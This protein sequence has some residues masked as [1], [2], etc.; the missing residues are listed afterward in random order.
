MKITMEGKYQ[1]RGESG[2]LEGKHPSVRILCVDGP[3]DEP[4]IGIIDGWDKPLQWTA[5]GH[6]WVS[7]TVCD[8]DI[9]PVS[10]KHEGWGVVNKQGEL[11]AAFP[12][13]THGT[14]L[15]SGRTCLA[16]TVLS[17]LVGRT[18]V[19]TL[20]PIENFTEKMS[21]EVAENR[22]DTTDAGMV[23]LLAQVLNGVPRATERLAGACYL[24]SLHRPDI[25]Y[26][27]TWPQHD[28]TNN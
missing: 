16:E 25:S 28:R 26:W 20:N 14:A 1:T 18:S 23:F 22:L 13:R 4:V 9:V 19:D 27:G 7:G 15:A 3:S 10:T 24:Y 6:F 5:E 21:E 8:R 12:T 11:I 17:A 2:L